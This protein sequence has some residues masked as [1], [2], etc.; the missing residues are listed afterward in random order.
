MPEYRIPLNTLV[1]QKTMRIIDEYAEKEG[2]AK[3]LSRGIV[4]D[5]ALSVFAEQLTAKREKRG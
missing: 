2:G 5:R 4:V 3:R 1:D